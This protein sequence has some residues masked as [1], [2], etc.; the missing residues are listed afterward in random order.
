VF[1]LYGNLA[2]AEAA[3]MVGIVDDT[4][5]TWGDTMDFFL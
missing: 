3:V 1:D 2:G 4:E 5:L